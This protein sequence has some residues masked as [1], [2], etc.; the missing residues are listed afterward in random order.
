MRGGCTVDTDIGEKEV[1]I[2]EKLFQN[3]ACGRKRLVVPTSPC[4][5]IA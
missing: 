2:K 1:K 5:A 3:V 4:A